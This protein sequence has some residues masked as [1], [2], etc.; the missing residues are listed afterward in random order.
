MK[1]LKLAYSCWLPLK[2]FGSI[3]IFN[4]LV[5][6]KEKKETPI[7]EATWIHENIHKYQMHDFG[8][9]LFIGG[10]IFYLFYFIEWLI[11]C[12]FAPFGYR[13]YYSISFEQEAYRNQKNDKYLEE[14]KHF[15]WLKYVFKLKKR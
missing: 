1:P 6:R 13:A 10:I 14:R 15:A 9:G 5:R 4:Y 8:L 3:T 2:G 7:D 12:L 11:K